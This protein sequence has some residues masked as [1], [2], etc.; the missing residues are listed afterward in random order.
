MMQPGNNIIHY[1]GFLQLLNRENRQT[2]DKS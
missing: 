1:N 2:D